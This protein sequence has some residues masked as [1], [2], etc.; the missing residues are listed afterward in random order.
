MEERVFVAQVAG[1]GAARLHAEDVHPQFSCLVSPRQPIDN[2]YYLDYFMTFIDA[3]RVGTQ[4]GVNN[5]R[6][7]CVLQVKLVIKQNHSG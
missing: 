1:E 2:S 7:S 3:R 5:E 6:S 4:L